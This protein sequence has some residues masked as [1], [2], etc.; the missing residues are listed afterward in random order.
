MHGA[1]APA[2]FCYGRRIIS[3]RQIGKPRDCLQLL[4]PV[5]RRFVIGALREG[6]RFKRAD[7]GQGSF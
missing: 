2:R 7:A 5:F 3:M 1:H 6:C 4:A